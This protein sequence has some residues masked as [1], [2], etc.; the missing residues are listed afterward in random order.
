MNP[1]APKKFLF[2]ERD[3]AAHLHVLKTLNGD[4]FIYDSACAC[5]RC[6]FCAR[7]C[8][9]NMLHNIENT[10]PRGRNQAL[11]FVMEGRLNLKKH[12]KHLAQTAHSCML[13][14][15][16]TRECFAK[17]PTHEHML[18][19]ERATEPRN[20]PRVSKLM[21]FI[22][23]KMPKLFRFFMV[24][25]RIARVLGGVFAL[26]SFGILKLNPLRCIKQAADL[27]DKKSLF[28]FCAKGKVKDPAL[29]YL[30]C[31][32]STYLH[33]RLGRLNLNLLSKK[34]AVETLFA[35]T[36]MYY[37]IYGTLP[38]ARLQAEKLINLYK[39]K[40]DAKK[41]Q[42]LVTDSLE[43]L[44]FIK[45]YPQ[46]FIN[47]PMYEDAVFLAANTVF[48]A[49][50]L[51]AETRESDAKTALSKT[52]SFITEDFLYQ[53]SEKLLKKAFKNYTSKWHGQEAPLPSL[54]WHL[55]FRRDAREIIKQK[56][57]LLKEN[58]IDII[59][60]TSPIQMLLLKLYSKSYYPKIRVVSLTEII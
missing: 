30:P 5:N 42:P 10:S 38:E 6:A 33:P 17:V 27:T 48:I 53:S 45:K 7:S 51:E 52:N 44:A 59:A 60:L 15:A 56:I 32:E 43:V 31:F 22:Y 55:M 39:E 49:D 57:L 3:E 34:G 24:F 58:E 2:N 16:C 37:Y 8:A 14:G 12:K 1:Y 40:A 47:T 4:R 25:F 26:D 35:H 13:C 21:F 19:L 23:L 41:A 28:S 54:G 36:G 11:R 46:I 20:L 29:F 9:V 18:E 50:K